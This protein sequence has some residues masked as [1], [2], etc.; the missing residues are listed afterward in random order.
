MITYYR[1][2]SVLVTSAAIQVDG[3]SYPLPDL[4][5]VW[6]R[7]GERSWRIL[8]GRGALLATVGIPVVLA[9]CGVIAALAWRTTALNRL[10]VIAVA[11]LVGMLTGPL[12]DYV[13][14]HVD[15]SYAHG[16][17]E[18]EIWAEP[19]GG[20]G[21][22]GAPV[23]LWHTRDALRF[24]QVYRAIQRAVENHAPRRAVPPA[25]RGRP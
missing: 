25:H 4:A 8:A 10:A 14:E 23:R 20:E 15:R 2:R 7:R 6:H 12:L 3:R 24:G 21:W 9:L 1:D 16:A 5:R 18:Y 22:R 11:A 19:R 13:L 17:H